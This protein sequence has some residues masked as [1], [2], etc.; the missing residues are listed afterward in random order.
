MIRVSVKQYCE[1]C[2]YF[3]PDVVWRGN[4]LTEI[5]D[6]PSAMYDT[7]VSCKHINICERVAQK[8]RRTIRVT[9]DDK[10]TQIF[11]EEEKK[12]D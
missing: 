11:K 3:D 5:P 7:V 10:N 6:S 8:S 1:S 9:L 12:D 2:K 4:L